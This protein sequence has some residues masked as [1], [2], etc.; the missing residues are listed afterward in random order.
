MGK[1]YWFYNYVLCKWSNVYCL[2]S[3]HTFIARSAAFHYSNWHCHLASASCLGKIPFFVKNGP[4]HSEL[5]VSYVRLHVEA[6][7]SFIVGP[8]VYK[9]KECFR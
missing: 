4:A 6:V 2:R 5:A 3:P 9:I 7:S 8:F 1:V